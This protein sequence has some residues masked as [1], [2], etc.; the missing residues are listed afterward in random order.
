M[1]E[2]DADTTSVPR[3]RL[4]EIGTTGL[5]L[6]NGQILEEARRELRFPN[7]IKVYK[8]MAMDT[9]LS[10]AIGLY[11]M[12]IARVGW[13]CVPPDSASEVEKARASFVNSCLTDMEHS[14]FDFIKEVVSMYTFGF[15]VHEK[16]FRRRLRK[17]GSRFN[18]GLVGIRKLPIRSQDTID[19]WL[20]SADGRNLLGVEQNLEDVI[21]Y[22]RYKSQGLA[23]SV[24]IPREKFLLFRCNVKRDN[25]EGQSPLRSCYLSWKWRTAIEEHEAIGVSREMRGIPV[26]YIPPRYMSADASAEEK[27]IYQYYQNVI[28]NIHANEQA[29][30]VMPMAY[31]PESR[32]PLFKFELL[33]VTGTKGYDT[34]VI[35]DRYD[36]KM[37]MSF[38]ADLLKM[39]QEK[40]GSFSL[41]G[42][43]TNILAMAIEHRLQ[44]IKTVLDGDLIPQ[45]FALNGWEDERLPQ[46]QYD[47]LDEADLDEFSKAIQR[48]F[49][50]NA[51]EFDRDVANAIREKMGWKLKP[52]N[53]DIKDDELLNNRS[54][55]GDG[56][57]TAGPGTST[58]PGGR[59][60]TAANTES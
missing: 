32:Q 58:S 34:S 45:L 44:E 18:D 55:S 52:E 53:E 5:K 57:A 29:G 11:E 21:D 20:Y 41:A 37:L 30:L 1:A 33:S 40:V 7:S 23:T 8:Q 60:P 12:M 42:A 39:G 56:G 26:C 36:N 43:K 50:V 38:Y 51:V 35:I 46:M 59:D 28:R 24:E 27:A 17:T 3:L 48:V 31:D 2:L 10:S 49:S 9:T 25:P 19:K 54:R 16:V 14:F 22:Y 6:T 47:D 13:K 15:S 4:G